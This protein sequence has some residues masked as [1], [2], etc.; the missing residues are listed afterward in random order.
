MLFVWS[1][2]SQEDKMNFLDFYMKHIRSTIYAIMSG[3]SAYAGTTKPLIGF[4]VFFA[5]Q[6]IIH[7]I[8]SK[9]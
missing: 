8:N 1:T 7:A 3:V 6:A 4:A 9:E 5:L 2:L